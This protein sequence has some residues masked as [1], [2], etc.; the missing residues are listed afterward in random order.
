MEINSFGFPPGDKDTWESDLIYEY[1]DF[2]L[3]RFYRAFT[4]NH[5]QK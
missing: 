5:C 3:N 2:F 1:L 4:I